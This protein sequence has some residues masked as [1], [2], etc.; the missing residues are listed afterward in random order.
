AEERP[1]ALVCS[2]DELVRALRRRVRR[3][4]V[5]VVLAQVAGDRVDHLVGALRAAGPVEE[6]EP[7]VEGP[8]ACADRIDVERG[9]AHATSQAYVVSAVSDAPMKQS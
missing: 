2:V 6:G 8:E 4:H 5:R 7:P 1:R 9:D 3:A